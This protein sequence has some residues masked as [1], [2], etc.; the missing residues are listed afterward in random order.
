MRLPPQS[1][2][3]PRRIR[4]QYRGVADTARRDLEGHSLTG[5]SLYHIDNLSDGMACPGT[6]VKLSAGASVE[7]IV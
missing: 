3:N 2:V 1:L 4:Y 5:N 7:Q 6:A